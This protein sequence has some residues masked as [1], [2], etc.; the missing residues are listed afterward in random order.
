MKKL[1][2]INCCI[3]SK[4][5]TEKLCRDYLDIIKS[6]SDFELQELFVPSLHLMPIDRAALEQ[7]DAD[8][9]NQL[10]HTESYR[11]A[12]D[13]ASADAI[14]I[15]APYWD[16][17]FPSML[18]VY[19]EHICVNK[20]TLGYDEH[21]KLLKKC[22]A[23]RLVYITTA[24]GYI[25]RHSSV[26]I[27]LEELCAM[28]GIED[29]RFYCAQGLDIYPHKV[30]QILSDTLQE[31]LLDRKK[32]ALR[33]IPDIEV[34]AITDYHTIGLEEE[35]VSL[36]ERGF[37]VCS[38]YYLNGLPGSY[39]DCYVRK[40]VADLL[41]KAQSLLP[42]GIKFRIYDAYRPIRIQQVLWDYFYQTVSQ[43]NPGLSEEEIEQKTSF[44]V[45][46]P[47]YDMSHPPLHS[48]GGAVDL[49]LMN[50]DGE[51]LDMGTEFDTFKETAWAY[52]FEKNNSN[53]IA[54]E[55][56][57]ILYHAMLDAGFTNLPSEWWHYDFGDKYWA[58][59]TG[60]DA[61]YQGISDKN[62]PGQIHE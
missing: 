51:S 20:I 7:R 54:R 4:S 13:F 35:L 21:G 42:K 19:F 58:Y 60:R 33:G 37:E 18:K 10:L 34:P 26:Q 29:V 41:E 11:L 8:T 48:T 61:L 46:K 32:V 17:S 6:E 62:F 52:Y 14:V 36:K 39:P 38:Q 5:R 45:S 22:R 16:A 24:G 15:A 9:R 23:T 25:R 30:E 43:E 27:Y 55:N 50:E 56:R 12:H 3:R 49:S 31:M 47:S 53:L 2:F 28:F 1:L 40:T 59:F 57:R 44:F